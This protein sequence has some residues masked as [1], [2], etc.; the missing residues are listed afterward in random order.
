[1]DQKLLTAIK[2]IIC[3]GGDIYKETIG[4][5]VIINYCTRLNLKEEIKIF[6]NKERL[7]NRVDKRV[8]LTFTYPN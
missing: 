1:V 3:R 2:A 8:S 4:G 6:Q 7:K 5:R